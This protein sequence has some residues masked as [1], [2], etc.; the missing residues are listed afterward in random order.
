MNHSVVYK[1]SFSA[2]WREPISTR[3]EEENRSIGKSL[4]FETKEP[5]EF[6]LKNYQWY[7]VSVWRLQS[8]SEWCSTE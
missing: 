2:P 7:L 3:K 6:A 8:N 5:K 1:I 4:I